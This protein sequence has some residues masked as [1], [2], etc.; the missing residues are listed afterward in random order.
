LTDAD[1]AR[2]D[3]ANVYKLVANATG[4]KNNDIGGF[5]EVPWTNLIG[6]TRGPLNP[7]FFLQTDWPAPNTSA[8]GAGGGPVF[9]GSS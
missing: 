9:V 1:G 7:I 5:F 6:T 4:W 3:K 2:R 8:V